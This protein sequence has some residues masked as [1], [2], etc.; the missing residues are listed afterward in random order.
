MD[1]FQSF[2]T[3]AAEL[4]LAAP[5]FFNWLAPVLLA[6]FGG[7]VWLAYWLGSKFS[8]AENDGLKAQLA[9]LAERLNLVKDQ[10]AISSKEAADTK[11]QFDIVRRQVANQAPFKDL[12]SSTAALETTNR[13]ACE[14]Q[15]R[16]FRE[17]NT[18]KHRLRQ[19]W[20]PHVARRQARRI[21]EALAL[22]GLSGACWFSFRGGHKGSSPLGIRPL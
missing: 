4:Y 17:P 5:Q 20:Q 15:R 19:R 16:G 22:W 3:K 12:Q 1:G 13:K 9:V 2:M 11:A 18:D 7:S 6:L 21:E 14:C 8:K 10:A